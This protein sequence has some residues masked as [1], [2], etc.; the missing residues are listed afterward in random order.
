MA[1]KKVSAAKSALLEKA[2]SG[3]AVRN[4][5]MFGCPAWYAGETWFAGVHQD[6]VVLRLSPEDQAEFRAAYPGA[7]NFEPF[8]GRAMREFLVLPQG[9]LSDAGELNRWL[10]RSHAAAL[11]RPA[12]PKKKKKAKV[13]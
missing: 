6:D 12:K 3:F 7:A 13:K 9:L 2:L 5:R 11:A 8:P 1:W 10:A 4:Q